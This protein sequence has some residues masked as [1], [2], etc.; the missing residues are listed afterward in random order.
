MGVTNPALPKY[1][2]SRP[3]IPPNVSNSERNH[4]T[5]TSG[6]VVIYLLMPPTP[7]NTPALL[8]APALPSGTLGI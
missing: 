6:I 8:H 2:I 5:A 1:A 7:A 3:N 4:P